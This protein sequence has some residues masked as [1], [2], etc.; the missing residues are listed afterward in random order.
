MRR[1]NLPIVLATLTFAACS[2]WHPRSAPTTADNTVFTHP[3][4]VTRTD[5]SVLVLDGAQV[6][7]DSL[8]GSAAAARVAVALRDIERVDE[9]KP[10]P[11]RTTGLVLGIVV[12]TLALL[13]VV[14]AA[15]IPPNWN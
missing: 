5:H 15:A 2:S 11:L 13:A 6:V 8:V 4:R 3:V 14:A 7:G 12:G 10:S 9:R 1:R